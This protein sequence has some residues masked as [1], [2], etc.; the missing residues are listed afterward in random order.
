MSVTFGRLA[1]TNSLRSI[2]R[3][4]IHIPPRSHRLKCKD[5]DEIPPP[6]QLIESPPESTP[7]ELKANQLLAGGAVGFGVGLFLFTRVLSGGPTFSDLEAQATSYDLAQANGKPTVVEF[8]ARW[9][10]KLRGR[11]TITRLCL[12]GV[13]SVGRCCPTHCQ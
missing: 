11:Q 10:T 1:C 7:G 2:S 4:K 6:P 13:K 3:P 12:T 9:Y 8:Y 5:T